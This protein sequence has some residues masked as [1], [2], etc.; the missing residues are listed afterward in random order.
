MLQILKSSDTESLDRLTDAADGRAAGPSSLP[1]P[2]PIR[3]AS[4]GRSSL[5]TRHT[6]QSN[7]AAS[8]TRAANTV[9]ITQ[10]NGVQRNVRSASPTLQSQPFAPESCSDD[11]EAD[12]V[13][14]WGGSP[15]STERLRSLSTQRSSEKHSEKEA[16]NTSGSISDD[17]S[18]AEADDS[19]DDESGSDEGSGIV[20]YGHV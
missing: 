1:T 18:D 8:A 12:E 15:V 5:F 6:T 17:S 10:G 13:T 19:S 3:P 2:Y 4:R 16:S 20:L 9:P 14:F 7:I 11:D